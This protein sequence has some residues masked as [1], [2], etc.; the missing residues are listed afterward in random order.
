MLLA[1]RILSIYCTYYEPRRY[2]NSTVDILF[3][4]TF[5]S[6]KDIHFWRI[7][8]KNRL[9]SSFFAIKVHVIF[10]EIVKYSIRGSF[11]LT[12]V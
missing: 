2:K 9:R 4:F 10:D 6:I 12:F 5:I 11:E 7:R 1:L 8:K 3:R